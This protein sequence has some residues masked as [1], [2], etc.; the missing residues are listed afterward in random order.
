MA[1]VR[2]S[3]GWFVFTTVLV[4]IVVGSILIG[5]AT[6]GDVS[7]GPGPIA[8][9]ILVFIVLL[10]LRLVIRRGRTRKAKGL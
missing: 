6:I 3:T 4:S 8:I 9:W 10:P 2:Q 5:L 7:K 1:G